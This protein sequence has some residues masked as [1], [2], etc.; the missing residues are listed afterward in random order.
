MEHPTSYLGNKSNF[1]IEGVWPLGVSGQS[2][3]STN[4]STTLEAHNKKEIKAER[5]LLD[6][7]KDHLI[8][9]LSEKKMAKEMFD[10]LVSL[11]QRKN[12]N[13]KMVLR[14]K[15]RSVHMSRYDNVTNYLMRIT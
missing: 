2:S 14:N 8:P 4:R 9:H 15:L 10:A 7:V 13:R 3:Y 11:F 12:M 6:S 5:V 1:G